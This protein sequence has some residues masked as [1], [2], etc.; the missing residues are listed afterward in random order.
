MPST[1]TKL[2]RP[3]SGDVAQPPAVGTEHQRVVANAREAGLLAAI[4]TTNISP[5]ALAR[6]ANRLPSGLKQS[7]AE[8]VVRLALAAI[9][10]R[11]PLLA[12]LG[13]IGEPAVGTKAR[14]FGGDGLVGL[15]LAAVEHD[16][17]RAALQGG[18]GQ[19]VAVGAEG[20]VAEVVVGLLRLAVDHRSTILPASTAKATRLPS[21]LKWMPLVTPRNS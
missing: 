11:E 5:P 7:A 16:A 4:D 9:D 19:M 15:A 2:A 12:R 14:A 13:H 20:H 18:I 10:D 6:Y 8:V 21:G 1:T 3:R 17:P